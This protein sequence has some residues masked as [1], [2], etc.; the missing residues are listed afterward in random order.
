M[1]YTSSRISVGGPAKEHSL[2]TTPPELRL[3][4]IA[5]NPPSPVK[6]HQPSIPETPP[7][8]RLSTKRTSTQFLSPE[9]RLNLFLSPDKRSSSQMLSPSHGNPYVVPSS[10]GT[11]LNKRVSTN[12]YKFN[13]FPMTPDRNG[14]EE[15]DL[16]SPAAF[17]SPR[18]KTTEQI[19]NSPE[20][21]QEISSNLKKRLSHAFIKVQNGYQHGLQ[22]P[23]EQDQRPTKRRSQNNMSIRNK[24]LSLPVGLL[25]GQKATQDSG[26]HSSVLMEPFNT[27]PKGKPRPRGIIASNSTPSYNFEEE[28]NMLSAN[29]AFLAAISRTSPKKPTQKSL[30]FSSP[31]MKNHDTSPIDDKEKE[32]EAIQ[33]L[34]SLSSPVASKKMSFKTGSSPR[35]HKTQ[36]H[37]RGKSE[38]SSTE[39]EQDKTDFKSRSA[40]PISQIKTS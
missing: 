21:L 22:E 35:S 7:S 31:I 14:L 26:K 39:D 19:L 32:Q 16:R 15:D 25:G 10:P 18:Y 3:N 17:A 4:T 36:A 1:P 5:N 37:P 38:S 20:K 6:H 2:D 40:T 27:T 9:K 12:F 28:D 34:L 8:K 24:H 33:S 29:E 13:N 30:N 11:V 23:E